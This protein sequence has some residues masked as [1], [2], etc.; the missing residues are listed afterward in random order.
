MPFALYLHGGPY[1][2]E[3]TGTHPVQYRFFVT[4][5]II[6]VEKRS[7]NTFT[8]CKIVDPDASYEVDLFRTVNSFF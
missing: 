6:T 4:Y 5:F 3:K 2:N 1:F 7:C 8:P